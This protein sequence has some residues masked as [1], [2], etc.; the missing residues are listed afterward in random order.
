MAIANLSVILDVCDVEM[1][2]SG[3]LGVE[4]SPKKVPIRPECIIRE[5]NLHSISSSIHSTDRAIRFAD[6]RRVAHVR[7]VDRMR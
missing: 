5:C 6:A 1:V 7:W 4:M 2:A 3:D